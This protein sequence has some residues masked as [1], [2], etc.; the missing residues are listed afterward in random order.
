MDRIEGRLDYSNW[1]PRLPYKRGTVA[2]NH[3]EDGTLYFAPR[4]EPVYPI[5]LEGNKWW[6][7]RKYVKR[8][9]RS[10]IKYI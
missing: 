7:M 3:Y 10:R 5:Y 9:F 6:R 2:Y 8:T 1:R 4:I